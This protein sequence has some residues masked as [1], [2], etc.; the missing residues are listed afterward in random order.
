MFDLLNTLRLR[1]NECHFTD[2]TF[3]R[4]FLNENF[5]TSIMISMK[6]VLKGSINNIPAL[7][8]IMARRWPG[9][10]PLSEKIMVRLPTHI[11]V[12]RP[13]WVKHGIF[14]DLGQTI[15]LGGKKTKVS[16]TV[17]RASNF[18]TGL[19]NLRQHHLLPLLMLRG[20]MVYLL[21]NNRACHPGGHCWD[22][23]P[24][25]LSLSQVMAMHFEILITSM[26]VR[27]SYEFQWLDYTVGYQHSSSSNGCQVTC[28]I[29][30]ES[31]CSTANFHCSIQVEVQTAIEL[32]LSFLCCIHL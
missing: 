31:H 11:S 14:I 3:K 2:N 25:A 26:G 16:W 10:K 21:Y 6:F 1:Q 4:I 8:Q 29:P 18:K 12:T 28:R 19:V 24:G 27:D 5:R 22:Y 17:K 20:D 7:I 23:Y 13:Q 32:Y 15:M 30:F 9:D